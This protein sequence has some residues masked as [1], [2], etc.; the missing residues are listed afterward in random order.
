VTREADRD[1][2]WQGI[3]E[4]PASG[5]LDRKHRSSTIDLQRLYRNPGL[6]T[7][8]FVRISAPPRNSD[9]RVAAPNARLPYLVGYGGRFVKR[10]HASAYAAAS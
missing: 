6:R 1:E 5:Y 4:T 2:R 9:C 7:P 10:M 8:V 3:D